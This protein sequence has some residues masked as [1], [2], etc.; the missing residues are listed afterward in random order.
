M[1]EWSCAPVGEFDYEVTAIAHGASI[2]ART[3][4]GA[5][6]EA[7]VLT[8]DLARTAAPS[9]IIPLIYCLQIEIGEED[10]E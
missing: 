7:G 6:V 1:T 5:L 8:P 3:E 10:D 2:S 4:L 9:E